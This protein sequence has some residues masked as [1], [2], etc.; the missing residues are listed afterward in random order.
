MH[1]EQRVAALG[2]RSGRNRD[3]HVERDVPIRIGARHRR[4]VIRLGGQSLP[5]VVL[6]GH[7]DG[8]SPPTF[9]VVPLDGGRP[10]SHFWY[11]CPA[12]G[13][14]TVQDALR[15]VG[16]AA[17]AAGTPSSAVSS[18]SKGG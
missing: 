5:A 9:G 12:A 8:V 4:R 10:S 1:E 17:W 2:S 7:G 11:E 16:M 3:V 15:L 13:V 6:G 14:C 18:A